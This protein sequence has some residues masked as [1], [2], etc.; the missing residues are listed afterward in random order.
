MK[1]PVPGYPETMNAIGCFTILAYYIGITVAVAYEWL[2]L[3]LYLVALVAPIALS[4]GLR[5]AST[6]PQPRTREHGLLGALA[7]GALLG[8]I[9]DGSDDS[10]E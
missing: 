7:A 5:P 1:H 2:P 6:T 9:L 10:D 8:G 4:G 3:G